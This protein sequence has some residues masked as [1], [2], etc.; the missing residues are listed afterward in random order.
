[1]SDHND[2]REEDECQLHEDEGT[3]K[4]SRKRHNYDAE[5][6]LDAVKWARDKK[7]ARSGNEFNVDSAAKK[8][9]VSRSRIYEWMKQENELKQLM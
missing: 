4:S 3:P 6:K 7:S 9:K 2:L 5:K 1:M 8:F